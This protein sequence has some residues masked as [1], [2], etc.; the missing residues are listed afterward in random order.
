MPG[1]SGVDVLKILGQT[2][3]TVPVI[4]VTASADTSIAEECLKTGAFSWVPK[5]FNFVYMDH[6]AALATE[7]TQR[8]RP[9]P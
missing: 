8:G 2:D 3:S 9:M 4:I 1:M 5:P 7:R 6:I